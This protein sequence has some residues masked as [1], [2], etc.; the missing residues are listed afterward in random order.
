[1]KK[2]A[3]Y[4]GSFN[5]IHRGHEAIAQ[6][7]A[8]LN[9]VDELWLVVSPQNPLKQIADLAPE[10][11]RF[12]MVKKAM[13]SIPHV[14]VS[15]V[16][17]HL[18]KPSFTIDTLEYLGKKH[19]QN[20]W[21]IILGEDSIASIERWKDYEKLLRNYEVFIFPRKDVE[22]NLHVTQ[23]QKSIRLFPAPLIPV[24]ST[25]I[26]QRIAKGESVSHLVSP[27]VETYIRSKG[28]YL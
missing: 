10:S 24:S 26:R 2:V 20:E 19:P 7:F 1:M 28:L 9:L 21:V 11:E 4:F 17:F 23:D 18:P 27:E 15:D 13:A 6:Y 3:L 12:A 25:E 22:A 16:E 14:Q 8:E 5:P